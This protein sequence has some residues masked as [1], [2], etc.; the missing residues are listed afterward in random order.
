MAG[1]G[2]AMTVANS[3]R[4]SLHVDLEAE[5][6]FGSRHAAAQSP[7][8]RRGL[9]E[10]DLD[11]EWRNIDRWEI[12]DDGPVKRALGSHRSP[13]KH[14]Y[15]DQRKFLPA[16]GW[17]RKVR[18]E[19]F[20]QTQG[21]IRFGNF[22][23][24]P[25]SR[26]NRLNHRGWILDPASARSD[27]GVGHWRLKPRLPAA[28]PAPN[29]SP[30]R[31]ARRAASWRRPDRAIAG[32]SRPAPSNGRRPRLPAPAAGTPDR[33]AG[34]PSPR[35]RSGARGGQNGRRAFSVFGACL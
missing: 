28:A 21:S 27:E 13:G 6:D 17:H 12:A 1:S 4:R 11:I 19:M 10:C 14:R 3:S 8:F 20:D 34:R 7:I 5:L 30:E 32:R 35:N 15:F 16:T 25:Q 24:F 18:R 23:R 9:D 22:Q 33:P 2:P 26:L 31:R 29:R